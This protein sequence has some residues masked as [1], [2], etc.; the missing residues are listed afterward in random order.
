MALKEFP[1]LSITLVGPEALINKKMKEYLNVDVLEDKEGL[2]QD[3]HWAEGAFGY[4]PS[5]LL[6]SI[7]DGM[8]VEA[9]EKE[10]GNIDDLL[11]NGNIKEITQYLKDNI[12]QYGG[13]YTSL[14]IIKRICN[15]ELSIKPLMNYFKK[16][17]LK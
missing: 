2:M 4:F 14:E 13:A 6:G 12:Y 7:Y 5:Y 11:K 8:F 1:N 3:I 16:K 10:L 17:Y 15:K 9:I